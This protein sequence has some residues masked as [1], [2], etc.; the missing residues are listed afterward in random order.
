[1]RL[2]IG[3]AVLLSAVGC[4]GTNPFD[5]RNLS[6]DVRTDVVATNPTRL[7]ATVIARNIS[8]GYIKVNGNHCFAGL[9]RGV[10]PNARV[11]PRGIRDQPGSSA[12]R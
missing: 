10:K 6:Y 7:E 5:P 9:R 3:I 8:G 12:P 2:S 1:M 11:H 4:S